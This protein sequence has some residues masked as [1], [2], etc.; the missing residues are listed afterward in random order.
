MV[1]EKY[2]LVLLGIMVGSTSPQ[3]LYQRYRIYTKIALGQEETV[4]G[5]MVEI[6]TGI[7]I[8]CPKSPA[9]L[10]MQFQNKLSNHF[11]INRSTYIRGSG[12]AQSV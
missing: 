2:F 1:T 10:Y 11:R 8:E 9:I 7:R 4:I 5:K 12:I 6:N 3:H